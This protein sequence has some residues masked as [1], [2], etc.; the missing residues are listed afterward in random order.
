[1]KA[2]NTLGGNWYF[3]INNSNIKS[4]NPQRE[5]YNRFEER[6]K[7]LLSQL[8]QRSDN[9]ETGVKCSAILETS[10][11]NLEPYL[12]I[13]VEHDSALN[14]WQ[15]CF[16]VLLLVSE[17]VQQQT[18]FSKTVIQWYWSHICFVP[19]SR[20]YCIN[21]MYI[22]VRTMS[23]ILDSNQEFNPLRHIS[24]KISIN[25]LR[26]LGIFLFESIETEMIQIF[27][28][29]VSKLMLYLQHLK[30][31]K[32]CPDPSAD[33]GKEIFQ[34]YVSDLN[35]LINEVFNEALKKLTDIQE[36]LSQYEKL[37]PNEYIS[38]I[39]SLGDIWK[40]LYPECLVENQE[41]L[42]LD[43]IE[44]WGADLQN[45]LGVILSEVLPITMNLLMKNEN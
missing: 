10:D 18:D 7:Q 37:H 35:I 12:W 17:F 6:K 31:F 32:N 15:G 13:K 27:N 16:E 43:Q 22:S 30:E 5:F 33:A 44:K 9:N 2:I 4:K 28:N 42:T 21:G 23:M 39:S 19:V 1:V 36:I 8:L 25:E 45:N 29:S 3:F 38:I 11:L 34:K 40:I 24:K 26:Q 20:G 14:A 41:S